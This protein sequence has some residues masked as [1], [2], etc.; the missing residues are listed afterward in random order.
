MGTTRNRKRARTQSGATKYEKVDKV[1]R[2]TIYRRGNTYSLYY[3]ENGRTERVRIDGNLATAKATASKV[4]AALEETRPTPFGFQRAEIGDC[5][6]DFLDYCEHVKGLSVRTLDRYRAAL[7]HFG[8]FAGSRKNLNTVDQV[9]EGTIED[10][11]KWMRNRTRTRNGAEQGERR[12][13]KMKGIKFVLSTCRTAFNHAKKRHHLPPYAENPFTSFP[14]EQLK[15]RDQEPTSMLDAEEQGRFF[16]ECSD[17]QFGIF[18]FLAAYGLRVGELTHLL[19]SDVDLEKS[20]FHIRSKPDLFWDV[21]TSNERVLP[22]VPE[23]RPVLVERIGD[24]RAGFVFL[25]EKFFGDGQGPKRTFGSDAALL[26]YLRGIVDAK[27]RE[28]V[29]D[30]KELLRAMVPF[31]REMGMIPE[32]RIRQEF[33]KLTRRIGRPEVTKAHSL[34]HA[35]STFAQEHGVNTI[36]VQDLL[37]HASLD[38]T[39]RYTHPTMQSKLDAIKTFLT[40]HEGFQSLLLKRSVG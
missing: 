19:I 12:Q 21:K 3:R 18:V 27:R 31:L 17:W 23:I 30:E 20:V 10:F 37:G 22:I 28:G 40:S 36:V 7:S 24:R 11:V 29:T 25:N 13:Y 33:M 2:V 38:M 16:E 26:R 35:F 14:I 32:K 5:I 4:N 15:E 39:R 34:R 9:T 6:S 1:G 8:E